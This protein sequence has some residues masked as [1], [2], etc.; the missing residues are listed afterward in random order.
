[1]RPVAFCLVREVG[2]LTD[3][4][5]DAFATV[6]AEIPPSQVGDASFVL[7][8]AIED[9]S[10]CTCRHRLV[11]RPG[12]LEVSQGE[13]GEAD[14]V[15]RQTLPVAKAIARGELSVQRALLE[16]RMTIEGDVRILLEHAPLLS[17]VAEKLSQ[18][19]ARTDF[20]VS[21]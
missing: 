1:M 4:W 13:G 3:E 2:F 11:A 8:S 19:A 17:V 5:F 16:G 9:G 14:V 18:L 20:D 7:E 12:R 6:V 10:G 15:I 21:S